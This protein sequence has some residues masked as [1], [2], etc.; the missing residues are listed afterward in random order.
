MEENVRLKEAP[1]FGFSHN[2][3]G[4]ATVNDSKRLL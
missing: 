4:T 2:P 3:L 1:V